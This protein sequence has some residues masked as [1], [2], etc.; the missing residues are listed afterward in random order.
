MMAS[1]PDGKRLA[2]ATGDIIYFW[3]LGEGEPSARYIPSTGVPGY[4]TFS[5]SS[6]YLLVES[7]VE[8]QAGASV[9]IETHMTIYDVQAM[10]EVVRQF[11]P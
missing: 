8:K 4:M 3:G 7:M 11:T 9:Q 6:R 2:S 5:N 10:D 1:S